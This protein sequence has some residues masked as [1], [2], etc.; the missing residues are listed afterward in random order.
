VSSQALTARGLT[1]RLVESDEELAAHH[2]VRHQ[3]FVVDQRLFVGNDRDERDLM[4]DTL[5]AVGLDDDVVARGGHDALVG[6]GHGAVV[7][8]V[9]LYP[10]VKGYW[11]GDR[12][13]VLPEFRTHNIG[14]LLVRFA[15]ATAG[16]RGGSDMVAHIQPR[17]VRFFECLGWL[18]DGAEETYCGHPHVPMRISLRRLKTIR[19]ANG[20]D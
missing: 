6:A 19:R 20:A 1:C 11:Q 3:V 13:A 15:V 4:A 12:L 7:G 9:R 16:A 18:R 14:A 5:H 10:L 17:N 2:A 8:A